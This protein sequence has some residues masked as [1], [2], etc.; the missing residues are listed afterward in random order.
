M[1]NKNIINKN[2][3]RR[4]KPNAYDTMYTP[5]YQLPYDDDNYK[6]PFN[7]KS[8]QVKLQNTNDREKSVV[9]SYFSGSHVT[10][11]NTLVNNSQ[12]EN[13][14]IIGFIK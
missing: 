13:N 3:N 12:E 14:K 9:K 2:R 7:I 8:E 11:N 10:N 4:K 6:T 1:D 5:I